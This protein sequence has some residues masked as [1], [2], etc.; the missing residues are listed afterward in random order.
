MCSDWEWNWWLWF[1]GQHSI[2]WATLA[3]ARFLFICLV[4]WEGVGGRERERHQFVVPLIYSFIGWFLYVP[5]LGIEP[6]TLVYWDDALTNWATCPG[7]LGFWE[8]C[9]TWNSMLQLACLCIFLGL[10]MSLDSLWPLSPPTNKGNHCSAALT[11][12]S[13]KPDCKKRM[14]WILMWSSMQIHSFI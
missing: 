12:L 6:A 5:W 11:G 10:S 13:A 8:L 2:H 14:C 1:A 3:R 4:V 7:Q 9:T